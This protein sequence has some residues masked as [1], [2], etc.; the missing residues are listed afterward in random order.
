LN[1]K[2]DHPRASSS[3]GYTVRISSR[4]KRARIEVSP[5]GEVKVVV[6]KRFDLN[7][8]PDF[9]ARHQI[10]LT[11][12]LNKLQRYSSSLEAHPNECELRALNEHW[13]LNYTV[14]CQ[15]PAFYADDENKYL[16]LNSASNVYASLNHWLHQRAQIHLPVM[17]AQMSDKLQLPF[18]K[19]NIK[20]QKTRWGSCS[21]KKN[22]NLNRNL[23]FLPRD[24]VDYL[25]V[26][27]LCHT[28]HMNHSPRYWRLVKSYLPDFQAYDSQLRHAMR[29][30]PA[31][32]LPDAS[33]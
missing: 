18:A 28:V 24:V 15:A 6:P 32:A 12:T 20:N 2:P 8:I 11:N 17:L 31:W 22:I 9:V 4:A 19:V 1:A 25:L 33:L 30:V 23:L 21:S 14:H 29:V 13:S 5:H 27:E 3:I 16:D 26:H 10:W 7:F